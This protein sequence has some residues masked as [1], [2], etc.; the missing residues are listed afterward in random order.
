MFNVKTKKII[1]NVLS[2]A[3]LALLGAMAVVFAFLYLEDAGIAFL[4]RHKRLI[5]ILTVVLVSV[6]VVVGIVLSIADKNFVYKITLLVLIAA[7]VVL[8][9]L[10]LL[11]ITGFME[12]IDSIEDLRAFVASYGKFTVPIFIALQFLQV[13]VLPIPGFIAIGAGVALFGP[14]YGSLY[15]IAGILSA[16]FVAFLIGRH[17]GYKVASWLVGK[18][19]LDKALELVK[20]KDRV[21]LTFMFIFPFFPDDILCFVAGLSSMSARYYAIMITITRVLSVVISA[22]SF[23]GSL[24]PYNTWWGLLIWAFVFLITAALCIFIYK[25][26]DKIEAWFKARFSFGK[27]KEK[28]KRRN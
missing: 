15:S 10:Y 22:Y 13:I 23:N 21:V 1:K 2:G 4:E 11:K 6:C 14:F 3:V 16:S 26:G 17:L 24:I 25:K 19:S 27:R 12:K 18:E 9:I 7:S 8:F 28:R 5:E 20:G